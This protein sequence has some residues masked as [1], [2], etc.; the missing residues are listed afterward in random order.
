V[1]IS[2]DKSD[3]YYFRGWKAELAWEHRCEIT[4]PRLQTQ[5]RPGR[6]SFKPVAFW[7]SVQHLTSHQAYLL[8][9]HKYFN[10]WSSKRRTKTHHMSFNS[11]FRVLSENIQLP[12]SSK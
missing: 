8:T 10:Y 7:L 2:S 4:C 6:D 1:K 9:G 3:Y 12:W 5:R 11:A